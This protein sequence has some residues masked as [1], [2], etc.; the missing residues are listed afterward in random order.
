MRVLKPGGRIVILDTTRPKKNLFSPFIW[1]HLHII[2]PLLGTLLS[3]HSDAYTYLPDS[4]EQF[5]SGEELLAKMDL[6]GFKKT[7]FKR[8][9][10]GTMAIHWGEK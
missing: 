7:G 1:I 10:F 8:F 9:M 3:G 5:L 6:A 4:T 2:I